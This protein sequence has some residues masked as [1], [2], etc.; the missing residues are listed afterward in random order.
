VP[1]AR[2]PTGLARWG[3][4]RLLRRLTNQFTVYA[5]GRRPGLQPGVTMADLAAHACE[6]IESRFD[7]PVDVMGVST[8]GSLAL[9]LAADHPH[10]VR[11]LV[12]AAASCRL[13]P[14]GREMQ[15]RY[16]ELLADGR[17]RS[18][19]RALV[20]GFV[21]SR[22]AR[23]LVSA[24]LPLLVPRP[25]DPAGMAAMLMAEDGFDLESRLADIIAATLVVGGELDRFYPPDLAR[26]TAA[27][28][29]GAQLRIYPGR[30]H[31]GVF[32]APGFIEGIL[33]FLTV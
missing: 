3:E 1:T 33:A 9:Q 11:R 14:A 13:S 29:P 6:G 25:E 5:V 17:H 21:E 20:P 10:L 24:V 16:A 4:L 18:S 15:L 22:L 27:G 31:S 7:G 23:P 28:I 26:A 12:V 19:I 32:R 8:S 30:T 2:N